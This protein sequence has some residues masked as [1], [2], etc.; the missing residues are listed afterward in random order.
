[1]VT[2]PVSA[3]ENMAVDHALLRRARKTGE[4]VLRVYSWREPTVS[5][6]RNQ[7]AQGAYDAERAKELGVSIVRRPTGGRA[8]VHW[9][10]VTYS[11]TAPIRGRLSESYVAT[12]RLLVNAL[13]RLGVDAD[14]AG[15]Q[16]PI[17]KLS[18]SPCF[19]AAA[20]G[21]VVARGRK[22]VGSAQWRED[23]ATMQHGSILI[24]DDQPLLAA[25]AT[26]PTPLPAAPATLHT[27][28]GRAPGPDA[29]AA[30]LHDALDATLS[31]PAEPF[32][33]DTET[34]REAA[35]LRAHYEADAW[36][37]RR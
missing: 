34:C 9:R 1:M 17:P 18:T 19:D 8:V 36:T 22:L 3:A 37:W 26:Q 12:N 35:V 20:P 2:Q 23:G 4:S 28:L 10:E 30:A 32:T 5:L 16:T 15:D 6:G 31:A 24:D 13:Q 29:I 25:I 33:F 11:V 21:E 27:L 14:L 7:P